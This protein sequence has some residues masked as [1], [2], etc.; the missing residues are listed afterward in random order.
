MSNTIR[1][2]W[3]F[4]PDNSTIPALK[5]ERGRLVWALIKRGHIVDQYFNDA[6][7]NLVERLDKAMPTTKEE[8]RK[9]AELSRLGQYGLHIDKEWRRIVDWPFWEEMLMAITG[10]I[11]VKHIYD[12]SEVAREGNYDDGRH[13]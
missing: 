12:S 10:Q 9:L 2:K 1:I 13:E 4:H 3:G 8:L 11:E 6:V 7:Q 5:T